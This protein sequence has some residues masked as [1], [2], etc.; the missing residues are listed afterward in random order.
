MSARPSWKS[1]IL[2]NNPSHSDIV[3]KYGSQT[4]HAH[5]SIL[6]ANSGLFYTAFTS[7]FPIAQASVYNVDGYDPE[8]VENMIRFIYDS[9]CHRPPD[10]IF[11]APYE[12]NLQLFIIANEYQIYRLGLSLAKHFACVCIDLVKRSKTDQ[13][14]LTNLPF[15][16]EQICAL[17]QDNVIADRSLIDRVADVLRTEPCRMLITSVP[18]VLEI[19]YVQRTTRLGSRAPISSSTLFPPVTMDD[20]LQP[21][22]KGGPDATVTRTQAQRATSCAAK[23]SVQEQA[24]Q[25][26]L[27]GFLSLAVVSMVFSVVDCYKR[28]QKYI[29]SLLK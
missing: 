9:P 4:I 23:P 5:K 13:E 14:F 26:S 10:S 6:M 15:L 3:I 21:E 28:H 17:Y 19:L 27:A 24:K 25:T 18:E 12:S 29:T 16:L 11:E 22:V 20:Y 8:I 7:D 2:F 1:G